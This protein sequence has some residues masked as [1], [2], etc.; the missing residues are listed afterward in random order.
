QEDGERVRIC[1][2]SD[3]HLVA[4]VNLLRQY[5]EAV[6][7]KHLLLIP[8]SAI[9]ATDGR[10]LT[11][12]GLHA[13]TDNFEREVDKLVLKHWHDYVPKIFW[14]MIKDVQRRA[15][16]RPGIIDNLIGIPNWIVR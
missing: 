2:M 4:C 8:E 10:L 12:K 14:N 6:F 15:V 16:L 1:D 13:C 11:P 3:K 7:Y 5:A 9:A